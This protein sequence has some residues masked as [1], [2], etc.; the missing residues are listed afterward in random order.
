MMQQP[1]A[2]SYHPRRDGPE[3]AR[4]DAYGQQGLLTQVLEWLTML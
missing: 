2:P 1:I 3:F 4:L